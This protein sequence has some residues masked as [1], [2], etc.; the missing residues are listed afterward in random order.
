MFGINQ[1]YIASSV[2]YYFID[3]DKLMLMIFFSISKLMRIMK[4]VGMIFMKPM[5]IVFFGICI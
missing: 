3:Y 5:F 2:Y 1:R 4:K